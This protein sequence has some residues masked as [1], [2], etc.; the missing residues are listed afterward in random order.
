MTRTLW[1]ILAAAL[2]LA[3]CGV[4][5]HGLAVVLAVAATLPRWRD[6]LIVAL[7]TLALM[8]GG[9]AITGAYKP[10]L[11]FNRAQAWYRASCLNVI[12]IP[13]DVGAVCGG[14][15]MV[16]LGWYLV[17]KVWRNNPAVA[18]FAGYYVGLSLAA[19]LFGFPVLGERIHAPGVTLLLLGLL[20][21]LPTWGWSAGGFSW[22]IR[23]LAM[24]ALIAVAVTGWLTT[25]QAT[26]KL[27]WRSLGQPMK[28]ETFKELSS[29]PLALVASNAPD[30][31]W[32]HTGW[33][34]KRLPPPDSV[35]TL[36][37]GTHAWFFGVT[38]WRQQPEDYYKFATC[39]VEC[40]GEAVMV[41][42]R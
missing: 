36:I 16:V 37:P 2:A 17:A 21:M 12:G 33:Q 19:P 5:Y 24:I 18:G 42:L 6:K 25:N 20:P 22:P 41:E 31:I 14:I 9:V 4:R 28:A 29:T 35:G 7:P 27:G 40:G 23:R 32:Y 8:L 26:G 34:V 30:Y 1:L 10:F 38:G 13:M 11:I 15:V 3:L 39:A